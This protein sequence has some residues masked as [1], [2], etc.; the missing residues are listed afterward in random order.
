MVSESLNAF[1]VIMLLI[2]G[3]TVLYALL[4]GFTTMLLTVVAWF[5][6][7][8]GT[9]HLMPFASSH[10]RRI[11]EP[12]TLADII[13]LP[14]LFLLLLITLKLIAR[15]IGTKVK[16]SPAGILDRSLGAALGLGLGLVLVSAGYLAFSALVPEKRQ[17]DW[18]REA[19]SRPLLAYGAAM[20][21]HIGPRMLARAEEDKT[22][23]ELLDAAKKGYARSKEAVESA[24]ETAY[25]EQQRRLMDETIENVLEEKRGK[26]GDGKDGG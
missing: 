4:K 8:I 23:A 14:V 22:G 18:V 17:P 20:L 12:E 10:A 13:A 26:D 24:A 16:D 1:D 9:L 6:A 3:G 2:V 19:Q 25:R 5:G 11:I 7:I 21:T 15:F